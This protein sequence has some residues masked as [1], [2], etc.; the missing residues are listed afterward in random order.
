MRWIDLL[1]DREIF[2][3]EEPVTQ[4]DPAGVPHLLSVVLEEIVPAVGTR[5]RDDAVLPPED[6]G[7]GRTD[8]PVLVP[9]DVELDAGRAVAAVLRAVHTLET[10]AGDSAFTVGQNTN[11]ATRKPSRIDAVSRTWAAV[12]ARMPTVA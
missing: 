9:R 5:I 2:S 3:D 4:S 8:D 6:A 1:V 7:V 12:D 10:T 11:T